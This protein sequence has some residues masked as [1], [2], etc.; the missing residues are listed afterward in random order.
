VWHELTRV[1]P[2][3]SWLTELRLSE[4]PDKTQQVAMNGLSAAAS[5]LVGLIDQSPL[6]GETSL[7]APIATDPIEGR[8]RFA[9]QAKIK[10]PIQTKSAP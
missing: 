6:F 1:L 7:T 5:S 3:H 10:R 2:A 4:T 9:L 8:E